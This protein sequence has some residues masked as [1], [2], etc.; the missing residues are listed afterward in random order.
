MGCDNLVEVMKGITSFVKQV[1][2]YMKPNFVKRS[3]KKRR[4]LKLDFILKWALEKMV[5][6][7]GVD[8]SEG[9]RTINVYSAMVADM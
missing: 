1:H 7:K 4:V 5:V 9:T 8:L 6:L 2:G 3:F